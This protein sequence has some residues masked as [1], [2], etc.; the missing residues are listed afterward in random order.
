MRLKT[1]ICSNLLIQVYTL[2]TYIFNPQRN[3]SIHCA[4]CC[5]YGRAVLLHSLAASS[6]ISS[7]PLSRQP[8]PLPLAR[9]LSALLLL[10]LLLLCASCRV[11]RHSLF[12]GGWVG[13]KRVCAVLA[14]RSEVAVGCVCNEGLTDRPNVG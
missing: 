2:Q 12:R 9:R 4:S 14:E 3:T 10:L 1:F 6:I 13:C 5:G 8:R 11:Q 7:A